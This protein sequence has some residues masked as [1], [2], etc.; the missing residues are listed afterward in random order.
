VADNEPGAIMKVIFRSED[1]GQESTERFVSYENRDPRLG[2]EEIS[3]RV[4]QVLNDPEV[5]KFVYGSEFMF[6]AKAV[7]LSRL[8]WQGVAVGQQEVTFGSGPRRYRPRDP[9]GKL[10]SVRSS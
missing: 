9:N 7:R 5:R 10:R 4:N 8:D 1:V 2:V 3:A 6:Q